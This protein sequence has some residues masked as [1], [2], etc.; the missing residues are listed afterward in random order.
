MP[1]MREH[2]KQAIKKVGSSYQADSMNPYASSFLNT[3][4]NL[5]EG[6]HTDYFAKTNSALSNPMVEQTLR[7]F[8]MENC[9]D[10]NKG[11]GTSTGKDPLLETAG[12]VNY[13][14]SE[15]EAMFE[16]CIDSIR[17]AS[18]SMNQINPM[19]G[20]AL[21]MY[22]NILM[23]MIWDK[24]GIPHETAPAD[25]FTR[26]MEIRE[27][28]DPN[29]GKV[30]DMFLNQN[31]MTDIMLAANPVKDVILQNGENY[32]TEIVYNHLGGNQMVDHIDKDNFISAIKVKDVYYPEGAILPDE[33]GVVPEEGGTP[34][35]SGT[36][37]NYDTW[38]PVKIVFGP[39]YGEIKRQ[40][41]KEIHIQITREVE[42]QVK[43]FE[44]KDV[45][46]SN[47]VDDRFMVRAG[48]DIAAI[49]MTC[50]LDASTRTLNPPTVGWREVTNPVEIPT[51]LGM[52]IQ[53]TPEALKSIKALYNIDQ[54]T[55]L[56][57]LMK[58][59]MANRRDDVIKRDVMKSYDRLPY[60]Q[61]FRGT[62]DYAPRDG[63][64][65]DHI[66]WRIDTFWDYFDSG[67]TKMLQVLNDPNMTVCVFGDPDLV[68]RITPKTYSYQAPASIGPVE[69]DFSKTVVTSD[70][71]VYTFIGSD[72]LRNTTE[73]I[74][75]LCPKGTHR[76][77]YI[78]YD[79]QFYISNE[80]RNN[81]N[82]ALPQIVCF[83]RYKVDEYQPVQGRIN[84]ANP[85][86]LKDSQTATRVFEHTN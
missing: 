28:H 23:N 19:I 76:I 53:V 59:A 48:K 62:F 85:S 67:I 82:P 79:Y 49:K 11:I 37:G 42:S 58:T 5:N 14:L 60:G 12:Q 16:N 25:Y 36:K 75:L 24:G 57:S 7:K 41:Q 38:Y 56:M 65:Q 46:M 64:V 15:R 22:K 71:R 6:A 30:V 81:D 66:K 1:S 50:K 32:E 31:D 26:T 54:V 77:T 33:N 78:I 2:N 10:M 4:R 17:E 3:V 52:A 8:F 73:F 69:L 51:D 43:E 55:K 40:L 83:D 29:T 21:P 47:Q 9:Y 86:G 74:V 68:R 20:M 45:I 63:Y 13:F 84:I 70:R 27:L 18:I 80:I 72:K 39:G 34:A 35:T 61:K 44:I